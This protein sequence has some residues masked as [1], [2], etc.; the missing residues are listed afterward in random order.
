LDSSKLRNWL[1]ITGIVAVVISLAV[2]IFEVRENTQA[3]N[4]QMS[5]DR[6]A[7][8]S[9]PFFEGDLPIVLAKVAKVQGYGPTLSSFMEVYDLTLEEAI[10]WQ[11]HLFYLWDVLESEFL[12][13]G[14]S[15]ELQAQVRGLLRFRDQQIFVDNAEESGFQPAFIEYIEEQ[16]NNLESSTEQRE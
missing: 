14:D 13:E 6:A 2:L 16:R 1:E 11:R 4:R 12:A 9:V 5:N 7:A 8:L 10:L 15:H 3:I